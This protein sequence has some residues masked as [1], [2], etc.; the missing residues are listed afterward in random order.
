MSGGYANEKPPSSTGSGEGDLTA[1][2][3]SSG[4]FNTDFKR[5]VL[6]VVL[7]LLPAQ[8]FSVGIFMYMVIVET[9]KVYVHAHFLYL[10][11]IY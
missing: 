7:I 4:F 10:L 2:P 9:L 3:A 8:C 11:L 5:L 6:I 1:D